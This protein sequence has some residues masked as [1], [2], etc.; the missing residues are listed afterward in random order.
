MFRGGGEKEREREREGPVVSG[1]LHLAHPHPSGVGGPQ[2]GH[3]PNGPWRS[4]FRDTPCCPDSASESLRLNDPKRCPAMGQSRQ[5]ISWLDMD[6]VST[7]VCPHANYPTSIHGT[8]PR[9]PCHSASPTTPRTQPKDARSFQK[10]VGGPGVRVV[11]LKLLHSSSGL[12]RSRVACMRRRPAL[13]PTRLVLARYSFPFSYRQL[14]HA[15]SRFH[16]SLSQHLPLPAV[17]IRS[18]MHTA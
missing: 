13:R 1:A 16:S 11:P 2:K 7:L 8:Y 15:V 3:H 10:A 4:H 6:G 12:R 9:L 18:R 5:A 17:Q 14:S